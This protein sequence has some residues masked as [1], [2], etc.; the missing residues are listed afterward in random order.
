MNTEEHD[1]LWRLLGKAK[2][3]SVSPMFSRNVLREV[4]ELQEQ[5]PGVLAWLRR[6]WQ[7]PLA[8]ACSV[9]VAFSLLSPKNDI[10]RQSAEP[11]RLLVMAERVSESPDYQVIS[12]LDELLDSEENSVW[13]DQTVY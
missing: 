2:E 7:I 10:A 12:H 5:R 11:D 3:P 9:I 1:E 13:L 6:Y 8:A 4:R